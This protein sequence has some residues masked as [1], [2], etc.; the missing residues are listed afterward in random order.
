MYTA[1]EH[2]AH[3]SKYLSNGCEL[4]AHIVSLKRGDPKLSICR[5][6]GD[7]PPRAGTAPGGQA[8]LDPPVGYPFS[9]ASVL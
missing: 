5:V 3:L 4:E 8:P 9:L 1:T 2:V 6:N 7:V